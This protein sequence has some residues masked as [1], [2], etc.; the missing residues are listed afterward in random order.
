MRLEVAYISPRRGRFKSPAAQQLVDDYLERMRHYTPVNLT[1]YLSETAFLQATD[2]IGGRLP[3]ALALL[4]S[5]G[6]AFTSEAFAVR[7]GTLQDAGTQ[8]LVCAIGP[9]DGWSAAARQRAQLLISLSAMT[10][11]HELALA[12]LAEQIYR[13]LTILAGHPYH[14]GH[15]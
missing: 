4:D 3:A 7:L 2:R 9:P 5:R 6:Q 15:S 14:A 13:A 10:F 12:M 11:P 1:G 8:Q